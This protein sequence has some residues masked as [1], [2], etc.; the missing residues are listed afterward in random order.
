[1]FLDLYLLLVNLSCDLLLD[2]TGGLLLLDQLVSHLSALLIDLLLEFLILTSE[3]LVL[4]SNLVNSFL[5]LLVLLVELSFDA[6]EM[7]IEALLN[8]RSLVPFLL[9]DLLV[10]DIKL[11]VL[12]VVLTGEDF[13]PL[14]D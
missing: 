10:A 14:L 7:I 2:F 3:V 13:V 8:R 6:V 5:V 9:G 11:F 12:V 1:M 4:F